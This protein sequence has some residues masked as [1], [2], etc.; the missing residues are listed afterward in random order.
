[1][2]ILL[3][4][5]NGKMGRKIYQSLID[6]GFSVEGFD[7]LSTEGIPVITDIKLIDPKK[8]DWLVDFS[9][10][11]ISITFTEL[12]LN[13]GT[14]VISGTTGISDT[15]LL[16]FR[17]L[18]KSKN[19][20]YIHRV[21]FSPSFCAY[22]KLV[23]KA[24]KFLPNKLIV[25]SHDLS[26]YDKPSG[27]ALHLA[28]SIGLESKDIVSLRIDEPEPCHKVIISN[29]KERIILVHQVLDKKAFEDGFMEIFVK[30]VGV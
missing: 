29:D 14:N 23:K 30:E 24:S 8:Y 20:K 17:A 1:M 13:N 25:E 28:K 6:R 15:K 26:K 10:E 11:R 2:K 12:F 27:S 9:N 5:I 3:L 7:L 19:A 22:E 18:A 4:G 16:E 21:N